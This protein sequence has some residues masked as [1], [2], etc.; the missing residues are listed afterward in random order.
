MLKV[1]FIIFLTAIFTSG[2]KAQEYWLTGPSLTSN[3]LRSVF[4]KD[5]LTGWIGGDSGIILHTSDQGK[6]WNFQNSGVSYEVISLFF[7]T[8]TRG[9]AL[10][11]ELNSDPPNHYGTRI[12]ST[13]N[14]GFSWNNYLFPDSNVFYNTITFRD[15]LHGFLGGTEGRILYTTNAGANWIRG[16]IDSGFT[17]GYP[18][19]HISFYNENYGFATGGAFDIAGVIW[20]TTNGGRNW[21]T[22]IVGPEPVNDLHIFDS[23]NIIGIG[24]DYEYGP[25]NVKSSNAGGSWNYHELGIFGISN[26]LAFRTDTEAWTNL[27]IVDSFLVS[28]DSG[29]KWRTVSSNGTNVMD[30]TFTDP[31]NGW[32][33]GMN[34]RILKYNNDLIGI[35]DNNDILPGGF[36]LSQNFPN[37]FNPETKIIFELPSAGLTLIKVYDIRGTEIATL[38]DRRMEQGRHEII[39]NGNGLPSGTYFYNLNFNGNDI[40]T[41][42]MVLLK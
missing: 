31:R 42:K 20:N 22:Q 13:T 5:S 37:P 27:S 16:S 4:F 24:G 1:T 21:R 18:V 40:I 8:R 25:S 6:T 11:W 28:T 12:L 10:S 32:A 3:N 19:E 15:S 34:G 29:N 17:Y 39:F 36:S 7:L 2:I 26:A 35:E 14:G 33:V 30:I 23:L 38:T 9:Y 41:K